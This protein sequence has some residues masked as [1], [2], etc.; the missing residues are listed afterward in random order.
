MAMGIE[1]N[2]VRAQHVLSTGDWAC[3]VLTWAENFA[4]P[5]NVA[6]ATARLDATVHFWRDRLGRA[7]IPDQLCSHL[8][9]PRRIGQTGKEGPPWP[10]TTTSS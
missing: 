9:S 6:E 8:D 5:A 3:C 1:G 7:R 4:A 10:S 2:C